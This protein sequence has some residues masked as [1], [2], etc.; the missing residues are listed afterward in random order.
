[1]KAFSFLGSATGLVALLT[2]MVVWAVVRRAGGLAA[3]MVATAVVAEAI[4]EV[5]K[6]GVA[7]P[8]PALFVK[9]AT[10][11]GFSFPSAHSMVS[12]AALGMAAVVAAHLRPQ[13]RVPLWIATPLCIATI[14]LSRVYL[15]V[16]WATDVVGGF[17]AGSF[18][19]IAGTLAVGRISRH[20]GEAAPARP[21]RPAV[22]Q[23]RVD[24]PAG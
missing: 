15:G 8:R 7:R 16:H 6:R 10:P 11:Y 12:V 13:L 19:L 18:V 21:Q 5:V 3:V 9:I 1:M 24:R 2:A 14:G 20:R 17:A 4:N 23:P 22:D